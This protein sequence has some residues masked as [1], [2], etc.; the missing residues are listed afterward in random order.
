MRQTAVTLLLAALSLGFAPAPFPKPDRQ[1]P[2]QR[3]TR[4][5]HD[6]LEALGVMWRVELRDD[7]LLVFFSTRYSRARGKDELVLKVS[8]DDVL[9][10]L[11]SLARVVKRL[12]ALDRMVDRR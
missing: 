4:E 1:T 3:A 12:E 7:D 5:C 9:G 2:R 8:D 10:T 6:R 11:Q